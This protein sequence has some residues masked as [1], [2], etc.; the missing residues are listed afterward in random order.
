M[1]EV[2][3]EKISKSQGVISMP[4]LRKLIML[5]EKKEHVKFVEKEADISSLGLMIL[6]QQN[7][8]LDFLNNSK[9][10][11]YTVNDLKVKYK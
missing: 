5:A 6:S 8:S 7:G 4:V 2:E 3:I 10:N 11:I 1:L 9:E